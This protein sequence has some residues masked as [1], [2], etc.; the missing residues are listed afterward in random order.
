MNEMKHGD[1]VGQP[2]EFFQRGLILILKSFL[3]QNPHCS[4]KDQ[5]MIHFERNRFLV[6]D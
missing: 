2:T 3:Q 6:W 4:Q 5:L 1:N